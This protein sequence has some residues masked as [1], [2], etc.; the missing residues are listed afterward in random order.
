MASASKLDEQS[1]KTADDFEQFV[2]DL[3]TIGPVVLSRQIHFLKAL[4]EKQKRLDDKIRLFFI[5]HAAHQ[6]RKASGSKEVETL[7][8]KL[9]LSR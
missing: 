4:D 3:D 6:I 1:R 8:A 9:D 5:R 7:F 2:T